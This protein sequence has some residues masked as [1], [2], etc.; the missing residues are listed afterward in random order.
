MTSCDPR[1]IFARRRFGRSSAKVR[2]FH[3]TL[4]AVAGFHLLDTMLIEGRGLSA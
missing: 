1:A 3:A 2:A 4:A